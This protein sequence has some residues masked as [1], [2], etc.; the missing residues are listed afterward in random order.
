MYDALF[1]ARLKC[2]DTAPGNIRLKRFVTPSQEAKDQFSAHIFMTHS[3]SAF[4]V[5][6]G[7]TGEDVGNDLR[8]ELDADE[9]DTDVVD[10][11]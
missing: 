11:A 5:S 3:I 7:I 6:I 4:S 1:R 10:V 9:E 2:D 8:L